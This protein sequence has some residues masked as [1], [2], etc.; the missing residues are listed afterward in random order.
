M[1]KRSNRAKTAIESLKKQINEHFLKIEE[2]IAKNNS[3]LGRYHIKEVN[4]SLITA[5]EKKISF[6]GMSD[7]DS[8]TIMG[9]KRR[10]EEYKKKLGISD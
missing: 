6:L 9:F 2:D 10:L 5:L 1:V 8:K 7:E 3:D 4:K